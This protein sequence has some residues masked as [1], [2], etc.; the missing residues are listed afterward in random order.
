M[1]RKRVEFDFAISFAGPQRKIAQDLA[2]SLTA[3][4]FR[5][6]YD[7]S[8]RSRL[9]GR[10]LDREFE[11]V[12]GA[13]TIFFVP[14]VSKDYANQ[15]WPQLEWS[16]GVEEARRRRYEF[17][18]PLRIDDAR[19]LGL[20][21]SVGY[22]DLRNHSI[23][24][25]SEILVSKLIGIGAV[26][27]EERVVEDWVATFGLLIEDVISSELLPG[28][29]PTDYPTLCDWLEEDLISRLRVV[30]ISNAHFTEVS[31]RNGETLS[32]RVGFTWK[33]NEI[34]LTFGDLV[35]WEVLELMPFDDIYDS[36]RET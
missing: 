36:P 10:R 17:I 9:L 16:I 4:G 27:T 2:E 8:F 22:L 25:A 29:A 5:V 34:P 21:D 11:W 19:L 24:D 13:G 1:N 6:F 18:L 32:I 12:F 20:L 33:S 23:Q 14:I 15:H 30:D 31:Q 3:A 7:N 35:W 28:H 26:V